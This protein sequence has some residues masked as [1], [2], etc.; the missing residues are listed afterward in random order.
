MSQ[1]NEGFNRNTV[2]LAGVAFTAFQVL[3]LVIESVVPLYLLLVTPDFL[4]A[5]S[6]YQLFHIRGSMIGVLRLTELGFVFLTIGLTVGA[7]RGKTACAI[8][9]ALEVA[10]YI[11]IS[12]W[13]WLFAGSSSIIAPELRFVAYYTVYSG[14]LLATLLFVVCGIFGLRRRIAMVWI[15]AAVILLVATLTPVGL[16]IGNRARQGSI[17]GHIYLSDGTSFAR[18]VTVFCTPLDPK[19][20][21][22]RR[23]PAPPALTVVGNGTYTV[24][25]LPAS[26]YSLMAVSMD[27]SLFAANSV[28]AQVAA[29]RTTSQDIVLVPGGTVS[30]HVN[31]IEPAMLRF[32][33]F[34]VWCSSDTGYYA[35]STPVADDGTYVIKNVMPGNIR[36]YV[37]NGWSQGSSGSESVV[38]TVKSGEQIQKDFF[39]VE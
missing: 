35:S 17:S 38:V 5:S 13:G 39:I 1:V 31:G 8:L 25:G 16:T 34:T 26:S 15:A 27:R 33:P 19:V 4:V 23:D 11:A 21:I 36:I 24:S 9:L 12:V 6:A 37:R 28:T 20:H 2:G 14:L 32:A 10:G 29:Q 30:G 7:Y 22:T 18:D 3:L